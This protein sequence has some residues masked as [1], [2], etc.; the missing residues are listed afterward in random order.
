MNSLIKITLTIILSTILLNSAAQTSEDVKTLSG[1]KKS[2]IGYFLTPYCQF[3]K[4]AGS[5]SV[6]TGVAVGLAFQNNFSFNLKYKFIASEKTPNKEMDNR[7]Y[8][9]GQWFG[10]KFEYSLRPEKPVHLSFPLEVGTGEIELD[11]KDSYEIRNVTIPRGDAWFANIEPGVAIE[12]NLWK[13]M[14]INFTAGYRFVSD[15][16]FR[17]L[18]EKD[19]IGFTYSAALKIGIF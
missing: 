16:T 12:I 2:H 3:G 11:L 10:V 18:S 17:N 8:L 7:F 1:N 6:I 9:D 4:I 5:N 15:L 13:Y 19:L 14:K